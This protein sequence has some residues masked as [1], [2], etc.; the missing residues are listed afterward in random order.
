MCN[1][2]KSPHEVLVFLEQ[3]LNLQNIV[4]MCVS[5]N[6]AAKGSQAG[7]HETGRAAERSKEK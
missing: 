3:T 2:W 6:R 4:C 7:V 5:A 1:Y